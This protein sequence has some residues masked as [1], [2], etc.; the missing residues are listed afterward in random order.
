MQFPIECN[1]SL[2]N[3][4]SRQ[5]DKCVMRALQVYRNVP[6]EKRREVSEA[7][8]VEQVFGVVDE[9]YLRAEAAQ[10]LVMLSEMTYIQEDTMSLRRSARIP[11]PTK[12]IKPIY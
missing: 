4:C 3:K 12:K 2:R 9:M 7:E 6:A 10:A 8:F 11:V 5:C 1:H